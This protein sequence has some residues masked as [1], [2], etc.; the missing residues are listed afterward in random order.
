[1]QKTPSKEMFYQAKVDIFRKAALLRDNMTLA[2]KKLW[3]RLSKNQLGVRFKAQH[4][5][6]IFIVD[7]YCHKLKLVIEVDGL[8][9]KEQKDYDEGREKELE[10]LGLMVIRFTNDD[11]I[12]DI[13]NVILKIKE[14]ITLRALPPTP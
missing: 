12:H 5:V 3:Q 11:I 9:H 10:N 8:I 14:V 6:D 13:E 4:P 2:E 7:F 1:M